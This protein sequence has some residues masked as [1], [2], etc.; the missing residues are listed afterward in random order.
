MEKHLVVMELDNVILKDYSEV[1]EYTKKVLEAV[2]GLGH[3]LIFTTS[4]AYGPLMQ[5]QHQALSFPSIVVANGG[6]TAYDNEGTTIL[7]YSSD[8]KHF[9]EALNVGVPMLKAAIWTIG[10]TLYAYKEDKYLQPVVDNFTGEVVKLDE[11]GE[12][13]K[14]EQAPSTGFCIPMPGKAYEFFRAMNDIEEIVGAIYDNDKSVIEV[15]QND[16]DKKSTVET[17]VSATGIDEA[18]VM[19]FAA[20]EKDINLAKDVAHPYIMKNAPEYVKE[21]FSRAKVTEATCNEDGVAKEL[22]K[23]FG[24]DM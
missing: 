13:F 21:M 15:H 12:D 23:F 17:I 18:N 11:I 14:L 10:D 4:R 16:V 6:R 3:K 9:Q 7:N 22:V 8:Y 20:S 1:T 24:I 19:A 2:A 5:Q